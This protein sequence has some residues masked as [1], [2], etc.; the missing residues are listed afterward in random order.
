[1]PYPSEEQQ[2]ET[3]YKV[4]IDG[5]A[6]TSSEPVKEFLE[7]EYIEEKKGGN[8][9]TRQR[10]GAKPKEGQR[11]GEEEKDEE[12]DEEEEGFKSTTTDHQQQRRRWRTA[13]AAALAPPSQIAQ[14]KSFLPPTEKMKSDGQQFLLKRQQK[15]GEQTGGMDQF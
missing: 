3:K 1:M 5:I 2:L 7:D 15:I 6:S 9:G 4:N 13:A 11:M 14:Q 8:I 10:T 12:E